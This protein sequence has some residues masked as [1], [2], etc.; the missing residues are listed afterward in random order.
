MGIHLDGTASSELN[1]ARQLAL[2]RSNLNEMYT[3]YFAIFRVPGKLINN[4]MIYQ[5]GTQ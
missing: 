3:Q 2:N 1:P 4:R 5:S